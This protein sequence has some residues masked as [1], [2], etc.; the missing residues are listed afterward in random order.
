MALT[1]TRLGYEPTRK[2]YV[3]I[4]AQ[5][6]VDV[7]EERRLAGNTCFLLDNLRPAVE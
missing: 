7:K 6:S 1:S 3:E 5:L 4:P 2:M